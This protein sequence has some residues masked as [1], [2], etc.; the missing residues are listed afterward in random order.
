MIML[1][2]GYISWNSDSSDGCAYDFNDVNSECS[3]D[4]NIASDKIGKK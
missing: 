3:V 2:V 1:M 4:G